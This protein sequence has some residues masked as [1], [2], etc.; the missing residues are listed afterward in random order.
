MGF[1]T[2][3][4]SKTV[5]SNLPND[6]PLLEQLVRDFQL[7]RGGKPRADREAPP[8]YQRGQPFPKARHLAYVDG[9][10]ALPLGWLQVTLTEATA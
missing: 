8:P 10:P 5:L 2:G 4:R 1:A 3:W 6:S 7:D 9:Q